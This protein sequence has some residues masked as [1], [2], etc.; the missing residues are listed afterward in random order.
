MAL[1][2]ANQYANDEK[3]KLVILTNLEIGILSQYQCI[4][5]NTETSSRL[6]S[7]KIN[8]GFKDYNIMYEYGGIRYITY[9]YDD[10]SFKDY[11]KEQGNTLK[12]Q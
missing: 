9:N 11:L 4:P 5:L 2:D 10:D 6:I 7:H 8:Y 1:N 3:I 12:Y